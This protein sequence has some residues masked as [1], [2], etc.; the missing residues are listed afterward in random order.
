MICVDKS[1]HL[2]LINCGI[3][4]SNLNYISRMLSGICL[5]SDR[6]KLLG[7]NRKSL[8]GEICFDVFTDTLL[9]YGYH[10]VLPF[11]PMGLIP[12]VCSF[13]TRQHARY[14]MQKIGSYRVIPMWSH[15]C[16]PHFEDNPPFN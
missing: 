9:K 11:C 6:I 8:R 2:Y 16:H 4:Y 3:G 5:I 15:Y 7:K 12:D 14:F 13:E 10:N 1:C